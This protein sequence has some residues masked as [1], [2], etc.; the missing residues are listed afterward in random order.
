MNHIFTPETMPTIMI[1]DYFQLYIVFP[2]GSGIVS[3]GI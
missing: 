3:L 1:Y 2:L